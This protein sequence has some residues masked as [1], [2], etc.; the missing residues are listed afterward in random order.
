M[1]LAASS[2]FDFSE[3]GRRSEMRAVMPSSPSTDGGSGGGGGRGRFGRRRGR[4]D[5]LGLAA[6]Q[7]EVDRTRSHLGG[8]LVG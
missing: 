3:S 6:T 8:D 4:H 2:I 5:E 1:A 7:P